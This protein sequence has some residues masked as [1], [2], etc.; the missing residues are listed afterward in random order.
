MKA[1]GKTVV[2]P[3]VPNPAHSGSEW[4]EVIGWVQ[5]EYLRNYFEYSCKHY[6]IGP[7]LD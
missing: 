4:I 5:N 1:G 7:P 6:P 2:L 3:P